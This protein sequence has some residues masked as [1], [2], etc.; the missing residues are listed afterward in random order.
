M[1]PIRVSGSLAQFYNFLD[2]MTTLPNLVVSLFIKP[3]F[4]HQTEYELGKDLGY[5]GR[6]NLNGSSFT[7]K[8]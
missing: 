5:N 1:F 4:I 2:K 8:R 3:S 6:S 7:Q